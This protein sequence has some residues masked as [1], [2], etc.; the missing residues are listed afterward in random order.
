MDP[1][2][3]IA[4]KHWSS[5][6]T[7]VNRVRWWQSALIVQHINRNIC[8]KTVSGTEGGDVE[9]LKTLC[10]GRR[11]PRAV[12][13]GCGTAY[14]EFKLIESGIVELFDLYEISE[15]RAELIRKTAQQKGLQNRINLK[16]SDAFEDPI[17]SRYDLVYWKDA[18]HHMRS[19][20]AAV[21]WSHSVL[22]P[23]GVFFMN[24]F[25]GPTYMQFTDRQLDMAERARKL[26]PEQYLVNPLGDDKTLLPIRRTRPDI[27][28]LKMID[29]TECIDSGNILSAV[30]NQ[31]NDVKL[32]R[33]G[34]VVYSLALS[35]VLAN[36]DEASDKALLQALMFAD[37][38]C[39]EAGETLYAVAYAIRK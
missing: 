32:I 9:L 12:S 33:T 8:G 29:P 27:E 37:D 36:I 20:P 14:H 34:G 6:T 4:A 17:F 28:K 11:L 16:V 18:L 13:I 22:N 25:V 7:T 5:A 26:L 2:L 24:E 38:M 1:D 39:V 3:R 15:T 23:G 10:N 19:S 31:F 35:D 30:F 21:Q